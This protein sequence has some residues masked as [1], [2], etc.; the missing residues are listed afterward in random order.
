LQP[1]LPKRLSGKRIRLAPTAFAADVG[2]LEKM[3]ERRAPAAGIL[4]LIGRRQL[5]NNNSWMHNSERLTSGAERCTLLM[6]P[7]D[8]SARGLVKGQRVR[9]TSRV[10]S[11]MVSLEITDAIMPG[12]VSLPHG[13][14]HD[15]P[16]M[17]LRVA[18]AHPGASVN[19]LTDEALVD[20]LAGT[21]SFSGVPVSV[22]GGAEPH[23]AIRMD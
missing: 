2:R 1:T 11:V 16:G 17:R 20:A 3:L 10:G 15:R 8:A 5:R 9:V 13:W 12:V 4:Q 23:L 14:G 6:H 7:D 22:D 19:D 21:A 18:T